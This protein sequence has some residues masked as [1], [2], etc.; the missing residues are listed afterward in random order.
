ML[1]SML[2]AFGL[3]DSLGLLTS[4]TKS[5][6]FADLLKG[7]HTRPIPEDLWYVLVPPRH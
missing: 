6:H 2:V 4:F 5:A 1:S 7:F 3:L